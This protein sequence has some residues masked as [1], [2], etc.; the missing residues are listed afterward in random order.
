MTN[1]NYFLVGK[2]GKPHSLKGFQY[3]NIEHFFRNF[4]L[5]EVTF[6]IDGVNFIVEEFKKH[7][8]NR[9]LIKFK[10]YDTIES[11]NKLR[12][13]DVKINKD[14]LNTF[15]NEDK[16]PW[17]GFFIGQELKGNNYKL[18][19]YEVLNNIYFCKI[20]GVEMSVPYNSN[21]FIY[22]NNNLTLSAIVTYLRT[23]NT[24]Q[25]QDINDSGALNESMIRIM[26]KLRDENVEVTEKLAAYMALRG[27]VIQHGDLNKPNDDYNSLGEIL[28]TA[29]QI[30]STQLTFLRNNLYQIADQSSDGHLLHFIN[31]NKVYN[32]KKLY[33]M[34]KAMQINKKTDSAIGD[35]IFS[36]ALDLEDKERDI[37][38]FSNVM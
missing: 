9:N 2:L 32:Q 30:Y 27:G 18:L 5:K 17:P 19:S 34:A 1:Q 25:A 15:L 6:K 8:K 29:A 35:Y 37:F 21:F 24:S 36:N 3:I 16:L 38:D 33:Q 23:T 26:K 22:E 28:D 14:L 4:D 10:S 13:M 7:L 12:N 20:N 11:I 31:I